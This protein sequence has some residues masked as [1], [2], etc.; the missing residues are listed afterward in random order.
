MWGASQENRCWRD[1]GW[2]HVRMFLTAHY[3]E[4]TGQGGRTPWLF[5]T[6]EERYLATP[7][8]IANQSYWS[9]HL[10]LAL[11]RIIFEV[12]SKEGKLMGMEKSKAFESIT[13]GPFE[14][15]S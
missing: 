7:K 9:T 3:G 13:F 15:D 12:F 5:S 14:I 1:V 6:V 10:F 2:E 4:R 11:A 8:L